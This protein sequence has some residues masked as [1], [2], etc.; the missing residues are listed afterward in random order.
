MIA[1]S[2]RVRRSLRLQRISLSDIPYCDRSE[3]EKINQHSGLSLGDCTILDSQEKI[4]LAVK[5]L[6]KSSVVGFDTES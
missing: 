5:D 3:A 4:E 2:F 1:R 6:L